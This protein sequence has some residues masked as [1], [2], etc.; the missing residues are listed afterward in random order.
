MHT[1]ADALVTGAGRLFPPLPP[2][3]L[4]VLSIQFINENPFFSGTCKKQTAGLGGSTALVKECEVDGVASSAFTH[5][6]VSSK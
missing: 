6:T 5:F 2:P 1:H 4:L 3:I